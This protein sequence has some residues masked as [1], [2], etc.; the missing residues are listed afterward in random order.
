VS[1]VLLVDD[2]PGVR[3]ATMFLLEQWGHEVRSA[4]DGASALLIARA[5]QPHVVLLDI[6]LP[7]MDGFSVAES[8]RREP[9]PVAAR[10]IAISALYR[11]DDAGLLAAA[12]IDQILRKPLDTRF[13]RSLLGATVSGTAAGLRGT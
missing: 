3:D 12:G 10:L 7:G 4:G 8:L 5:W 6:G 11:E 2:D 9:L 13:L 1:R